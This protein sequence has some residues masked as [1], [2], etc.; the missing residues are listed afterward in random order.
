[1][2]AA[3]GP[4]ARRMSRPEQAGLPT[5]VIQVERHTLDRPPAQVTLDGLDLEDAGPQSARRTVGG[6][7]VAGLGHKRR[8]RW[9]RA[10]KPSSTTTI[11]AWSS[12]TR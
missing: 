11:Q 1:M 10:I 7:A 6:G 9:A 12:V 8:S 2:A 3:L 5:N 4:V